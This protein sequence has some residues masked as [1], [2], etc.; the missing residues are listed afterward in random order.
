MA[1]L[2]P[3]STPPTEDKWDGEVELEMA[4]VSD[5]HWFE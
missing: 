4:V 2:L 3:F 1:L 5:A